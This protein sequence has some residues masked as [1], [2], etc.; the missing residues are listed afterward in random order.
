MK[1]IKRVLA[2]ALVGVMA[3]AAA[4]CDEDSGTS[5]KANG[6]KNETTEKLK[7]YILDSKAVVSKM[8]SELKN[9]E[10][11]FL[12]WYDS[13]GHEE[14]DLIKL[15]KE[16][17]GI[18]VTTL[19]KPYSSYIDDV[20]GML[21][22]GETPDVMRVKDP[23]VGTIKLLQDINVATGFDFS[24]KEW[25]QRLIHD[26]TF[27]KKCYGVNLYYTP[28]LMADLL[29]YNTK[30]MKDQGF[31]DPW[32][33][34][35]QGKW[36]WPKMKEMMVK[37]VEQGTDYIGAVIWPTD[38][39]VVTSNGASF[40]KR[41]DDGTYTLN[42]MNQ[43]S[44]DRWKFT[45]DGRTANL[46]INDGNDAVDRSNQTTLFGSMT[47][48]VVQGRTV[49][50]FQKLRRKNVFA[51][52][53]HPKWDDDEYCLPIGEDTAFGVPKGAKNAKAVPYFLA[54]LCNLDNYDLSIYDKKT[55]PTGFFYNQQCKDVYLE[56]LS[57]ENRQEPQDGAFTKAK[58]DMKSA[59]QWL[60]FMKIDSSQ[61]NTWLQTKKP[62]LEDSIKYYNSQVAEFN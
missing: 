36:T 4:A 29:V 58:Q 52:V 19:V 35:K 61:I 32:E 7:E 42:L 18:K 34:W 48:S 41:N 3:V 11:T 46:F 26:W 10:I 30:T 23:E 25:D 49:D 56:I 59:F 44:L 20:A 17:T 12:N 55:N 1:I 43:K 28:Y 16:E 60:L 14:G 47:A 53:P 37:W 13:E 62:I 39:P 8:P 15:F 51:V 2:L 40:T 21:A 54:Y 50:Y 22:A 9:T 6:V 33:L 57:I 45:L 27:G 38:A 5:I 24:G 31:E